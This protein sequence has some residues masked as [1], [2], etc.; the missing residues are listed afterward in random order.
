MINSKL[1]Q[2]F[3]A[4]SAED[5]RQIQKMLKS[6]FFT[7]NE[8]LQTLFNLLRK[9]HPTF[10]EK[11]VQKEKI[12]A[13][14]FPKHSYKELKLRN[15]MTDLVKIIEQYFIMAQLEKKV[16]LKE[17]LL[18]EHL[19]DKSE[20]DLV[21]NSL[22]QFQNRLNKAPFQD[23]HFLYLQ[24][25]SLK[26][27]KKALL[28]RDPMMGAKLVSD[29][30]R[31]LYDFYQLSDLK[32]VI[33][34]KSISGFSNVSEDRNIASSLQTNISYLLYRDVS[35]LLEN[36]D[37]S[38]Y[39]TIKEKLF[40]N[41]P[42]ISPM[43]QIEI[44]S[45]LLNFVVKQMNKD[46]KQFN[47]IAFHLYQ[48]AIEN[49]LLLHKTAMVESHFYNIVLVSAKEKEFDWITEFMES[50]Q[51]YLDDTT[52]T[53]LLVISQ[54]CLFFYKMEYSNTID[55]LLDHS[56]QVSSFENIA[57]NYLIKC[58]YELFVQDRSYFDLLKS[59]TQSYEKFT[60]RNKNL[61]EV[62]KDSQIKFIKFIRNLG[63]ARRMG[64]LPQKEKEN[65]LNKLEEE[66][67]I[68]SRSW[69]IEK[70]ES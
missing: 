57:R 27:R 3:Q 39:Y 13:K 10:V 58:Y 25:E 29:L 20:L 55:S 67:Y 69:L 12:F 62:I 26:I 34:L 40:Q 1:L 54:A 23:E 9:Q 59:Q 66:K 36:N 14:V 35:V 33:E 7:A 61:S 50:H 8:N 38:L 47:H 42:E 16:G 60:R 63:Q 70:L 11:A 41:L 15:L 32:L 45:L 22:K 37:L 21:D 51:E 48:S 44:F 17:Q 56:F 52:K 65:L 18:S 30:R 43:V 68:T 4:L 31:T 5:L 2:L 6:P 19:L 49:D 24:Y 64:I 46:D 28:S 53:E